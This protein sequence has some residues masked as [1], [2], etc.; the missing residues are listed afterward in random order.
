MDAVWRSDL[1][2]PV[3]GHRGRQES[4]RARCGGNRGLATIG[5]DRRVRR[6]VLP[7]RACGAAAHVIGLRSPTVSGP[8]SLPPRASR[9]AKEGGLLSRMCAACCRSV[10]TLG[11]KQTYAVQKDMSALPPKADMCGALVHVC[12]GP[13]ADISTRRSSFT[14][15]P[16]HWTFLILPPDSDDMKPE[17]YYVVRSPSNQL[18]FATRGLDPDP[19]VADET[20]RKHKL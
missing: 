20:V 8:S 4:A 16:S 2:C 13:I 5:C 1:Q 17:G 12:F 3:R 9:L 14:Y 15:C 7:P 10:S 19:K 11:Q 6:G 18:W